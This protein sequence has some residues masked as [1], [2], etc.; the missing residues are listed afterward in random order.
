[1]AVLDVAGLHAVG[2]G[3]ATQVH[4]GRVATGGRERGG[5]QEG[6]PGEHGGTV[7]DR[8]RGW[9]VAVGGGPQGQV[10]MVWSVAAPANQLLLEAQL[11]SYAA[12]QASK[13]ALSFSGSSWMPW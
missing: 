3:G 6:A 2:D 13:N 12:R 11:R 10:T 4:G 7:A 9:V 1:M 5:G 8:G